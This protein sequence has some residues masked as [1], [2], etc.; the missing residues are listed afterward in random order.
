MNNMCK[1]YKE[2]KVVIANKGSYLDDLE[3]LLTTIQDQW[4][5]YYCDKD[6]ADDSD[7]EESKDEKN[8]YHTFNVTEEKGII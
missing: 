8:K 2:L 7:D 3:E 4:E 1:E 6:T 5:S